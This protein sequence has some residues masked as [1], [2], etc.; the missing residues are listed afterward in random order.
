MKLT[1]TLEDTGPYLVSKS[2]MQ[3]IGRAAIEASGKLW[4]YKFKRLH[5]LLSA[6]EMYGIKKRGPAY[7]A[8][9]ARIHPEAN[10][11]PLVFS[12]ESEQLAMAANKVAATAKNFETYHADVTVSAPHLNFHAEEMTKTTA[13]EDSAMEEIFG[14]VFQDGVV[15][16]WKSHGLSAGKIELGKQQFAA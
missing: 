5:F 10:G 11:R 12:G 3:K 2:E 15:D 1:A 4:H 9:K 14:R 8:Y 13:E 7:E 6:F 16:A